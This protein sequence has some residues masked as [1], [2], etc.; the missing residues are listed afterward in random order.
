MLALRARTAPGS[1]AR[2]Q[3][4][5]AAAGRGLHAG[6]PPPA[7]ASVRLPEH[8]TAKPVRYFRSL[9]DS[10]TP[11]APLYT[12]LVLSMFP[13]S[14]GLGSGQLTAMISWLNNLP[15]SIRVF[16]RQHCG[17]CYFSCSIQ[18]YCFIKT[19]S[20]QIS[21]VGIFGHFSQPPCQVR[22]WS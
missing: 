8:Q 2:T 14:R 3:R 19:L 16:H 11:R 15:L 13:K 10:W 9:K 1:V 21:V 22:H 5:G 17:E 18:Y 20:S 12:T 6:Q 4:R 7:S